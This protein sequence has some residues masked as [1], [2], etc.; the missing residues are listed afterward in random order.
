MNDLIFDIQKIKPDNNSKIYNY[1]NESIIDINIFIQKFKSDENIQYL[2]DYILLTYPNELSRLDVKNK[3]TKFINSWIAFGKFDNRPRSR[4]VFTL[5]NYYNIMFIDTFISEFNNN[6][7]P[8]NKAPQLNKLRS[9]P[10]KIRE[11]KFKNVALQEKVLYKRH[12]DES[13]DDSLFSNGSDRQA[14]FY[15]MDLGRHGEELKKIDNLE[16]NSYSS[17]EREGL[18]FKSK[19]SF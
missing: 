2:I 14:L 17:G 18:V 19:Y 7:I 13:H 15:R 11:L 1:N 16:S 10:I 6:N 5:I 9:Q 3:I 4:N 12:H 8:I